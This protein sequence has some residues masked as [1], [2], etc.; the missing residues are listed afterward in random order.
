MEH[1]F[2]GEKRLTDGV[3]QCLGERVEENGMGGS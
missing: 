2:N 1:Y 3:L